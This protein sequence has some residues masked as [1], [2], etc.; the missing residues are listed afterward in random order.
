MVDGAVAAYPTK[1]FEPKVS[2][3]SLAPMLLIPCHVLSRVKSLV[4]DS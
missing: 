1:A 3:L 2:L 4:N